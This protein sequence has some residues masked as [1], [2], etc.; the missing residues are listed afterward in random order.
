MPMSINTTSGPCS[1]VQPDRLVA[2]RRARDDIEAPVG[3]ERLGDERRETL[4]V[5]ADQDPERAWSVTS[6]RA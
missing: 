6:R 1:S 2:V 5:F 4:V 3:D